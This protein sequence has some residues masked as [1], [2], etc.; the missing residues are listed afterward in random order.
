MPNRPIGAHSMLPEERSKWPTGV[1][2]NCLL[3]V[4]RTGTVPAKETGGS[5]CPAIQRGL[6]KALCIE[7]ETYFCRAEVFLNFREHL[8]HLIL[9]L[10][11]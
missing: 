5:S 8:E 7:D 9:D 4:A 3:L 2:L 1:I 10:T 6:P 11:D